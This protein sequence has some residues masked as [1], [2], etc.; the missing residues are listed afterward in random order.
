MARTTLPG[1]GVGLLGD[2][3]SPWV[4]EIFLDEKALEKPCKKDDGIVLI[5][6]GKNTNYIFCFALL[7]AARQLPH[8]SQANP[9]QS[10]DN[11]R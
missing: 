4:N 9:W 7:Q 8:V 11:P 10:L 6:G 2:L 1:L 5:I 3:I